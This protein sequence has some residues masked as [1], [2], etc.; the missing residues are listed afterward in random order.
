[1][2]NI[3]SYLSEF[4]D[5]KIGPACPY[6]EL[7]ALVLARISYLPFHKISM[8]S[9]ETIGSICEKMS[10][11]LKTTD[12][13]WPED[14]ILVEH[15]QKSRRFSRKVVTDYVRENSSALE[16][17]FSAI[18]IHLGPTKMYLS[19]FGTDNLLTAWKEDFN[20]A[21]MDHVPAQTAAKDYLN[22][23]AKKFLFKQ[24][25]LGGHSKGGNLAMYA[26]ITSSD[27]IQFRIKKIYNYDGPG[28]RSGTMALDTGF[29]H[30]TRKI[31]SV[32]PQD[33]IIGRLFEHN[34]KV[35][36]VKSNAKGILQ[37]DIYSWEID[38]KSF[39]RSKSTKK[40]DLADE[41][42]TGWIETA[43]EE[44]RKIFVNSLFEV[45]A[46]A[47]LNGPLEL[48]TKWPKVMSKALKAYV[49]LPRE[50]KKAIL[51]V[52]RKLGVSFIR[53]RKDQGGD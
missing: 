30:V 25:F 19:F 32:I 36:V 8:K 10:K 31:I 20:L 49:K 16:K 13:M 18:T 29:E 4:G 42:I 48:K 44:E 14:Q 1:M 2:S 35:K 51:A 38:G 40:S 34:E 3:N 46:D 17:Q 27:Y 11:N 53:A 24:I 43:S 41:T 39:V 47:D 15:L 45:L 9:R 6:N 52:W 28:L 5:R 26:A 37:H 21:F 12:F 22:S 7:D 50:N 23:L 33:S